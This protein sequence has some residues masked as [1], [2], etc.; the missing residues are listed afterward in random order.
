MKKILLPT[1]FSENAENAM[2]YA[3]NLFRNESC[4]FYLLHV[5]TPI[6][7]SYDFHMSA[8]NYADDVSEMVRKNA[9]ERLALQLKKARGKH[10]DDRHHFELITSFNTLTDE[11][12][13]LSKK[14]DFDLIILGTK[15]ASGA[16]EVL[17]GTNTIHVINKAKCPVL[18]I[19]EA[20]QFEPPV[21]ILFPTDYK[22]D[23]DFKHLDAIK[24]IALKFKSKIHIVHVSSDDL[25]YEKSKNSV[26]LE[27]LLLEFNDV[28][29][30]LRDNDIPEAI[31][32]YQNKNETQL[33]A[34]INNK[35]SF[36]ENLFFKP[37]ISRVSL[38]LKTPFL[39]IP[40]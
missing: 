16:H 11:I 26:T 37:V 31:N 35:H 22:I 29:E 13:E 4:K 2:D 25:D 7:Y 17:F 21:D 30:T 24:M 15:G 19:P 3:L 5:Y 8:G 18:A 28:Y 9:E 10:P 38:H 33:L 34:M 36:F 40:S 39:V 12:K 32:S 23:Y 20:Y 27:R 14:Y 1:D 6:I